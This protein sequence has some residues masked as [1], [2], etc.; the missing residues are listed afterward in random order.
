MA[1]FATEDAAYGYNLRARLERFAAI[2]AGFRLITAILAPIGVVVVVDVR[3]FGC[4]GHTVVS[5]YG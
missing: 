3:A 4:I 1:I 2:P 5:H